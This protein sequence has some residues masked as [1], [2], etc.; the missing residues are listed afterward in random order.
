MCHHIFEKLYYHGLR[1]KCYGLVSTVSCIFWS[2]RLSSLQVSI[3]CACWGQVKELY[4]QSRLSYLCR[5]F[6]GP[7]T[8]YKRKM[9]LESPLRMFPPALFNLVK[10]IQ[11]VEYALFHCKI[12][13][14]GTENSHSKLRLYFNIPAY[15]ELIARSSP[16]IDLTGFL[17]FE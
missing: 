17:S 1:L 12:R 7:Y 15:T 2:I 8:S 11:Y 9:S 14:T 3:I 6:N 16:R 5:S 13:S 4:I 10:K